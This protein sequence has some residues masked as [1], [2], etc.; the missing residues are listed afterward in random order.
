M[1]KETGKSV[2]EVKFSID[3]LSKNSKKLFGVSQSTFAGATFGLTG[4]FTVEEMNGK[5]KEWLN[6]PAVQQ[7]KKEVE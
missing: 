6:K 7:E 2:S 3:A 4:D 1:S 5:I